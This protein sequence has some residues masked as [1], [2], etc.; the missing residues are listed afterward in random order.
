LNAVKVTDYTELD[1]EKQEKQLSLE[2]EAQNITLQPMF[3]NT[4]IRHVQP[5]LQKAAFY[6]PKDGL[7]ACKTWPFAS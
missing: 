7:S 4:N 2:V 6:I 1:K 5:F 3:V